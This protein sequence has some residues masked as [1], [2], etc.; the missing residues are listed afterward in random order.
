MKKRLFCSL[1]V[2]AL[3]VSLLPAGVLADFYGDAGESI[4]IEGEWCTEWNGTK[5]PNYSDSTTTSAVTLLNAS[6]E[7][8]D[9][10]NKPYLRYE[11]YV[12]KSGLYNMEI[13][14]SNP[15]QQYVSDFSVAINGEEGIIFGRKSDT[16]LMAL[17]NLNS[18]YLEAGK[19]VI[20][21][22]IES[23]R[24]LYGKGGYLLYLDWFKLTY[25][26]AMTDEIMV[27][28]ENTYGGYASSADV[29]SVQATGGYYRQ[30]Y[31]HSTDQKI[32]RD[33]A[34]FAPFSGEYELE[35][36][37]SLK[38]KT[39]S[40]FT[41]KVND[42][43]P[44]NADTDTT[45]IKK[46]FDDTKLLN[47][48]LAKNTVSLNKGFNRVR[49]QAETV[50]TDGT[51]TGYLFCLDYLKFSAVSQPSKE[52]EEIGESSYA[53]VDSASGVSNGK[54][55]AV[56]IPA[57]DIKEK[58]AEKILSYSVLIPEDGAYSMSMSMSGYVE[59]TDNHAYRAPVK[60]KVDD[61]EAFRLALSGTYY[62][63][64]TT[65]KSNI[66]GTIAKNSSITM[67]GGSYGGNFTGFFGNYSLNE[68]LN[69]KKG[70]HTISFVID[71]VSLNAQNA[72]FALDSFELLPVSA[73]LPVSVKLFADNQTI[74]KDGTAAITAL[75]FDENGTV[76]PTGNYNL[77]FSSVESGIANVD[78]FGYVTGVFPGKTAVN[79]KATNGQSSAEADIDI[80]VYNEANPFIITEARRTAGGISISG[81]ASGDITTQPVIIA[82]SYDKESSIPTSICE[83]EFDSLPSE[84]RSGLIWTKEI[85]MTEKADTSAVFFWN[86]LTDIKPLFGKMTAE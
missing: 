1:I 73:Q 46:N 31:K 37:G 3:L 12:D 18:V 65:D 47:L 2:L 15:S 36:C 28:V 59:P 72:L 30:L 56:V 54:Y 64:S 66:I 57:K 11:I 52:A 17:F 51:N 32:Y 50:R 5:S 29:A 61:G 10:S 86:G 78:E 68:P 43:E 8:F 27:S 7:K 85:P 16:S 49:V 71:D 6:G 77:S 81:T 34:V 20:T 70:M 40:E 24:Q 23:D 58:N 41:V 84:I 25:S 80:I 42:A 79:V 21:F 44:I 67:S 26:G 76:I 14:S 22:Y 39:I 9:S 55:L 35:I 33:Y 19:N 53:Y 45:V 83:V 74:K 69:L 60:M 62:N 4:I 13:R 38:A 63:R 82:A 48:M 75:V